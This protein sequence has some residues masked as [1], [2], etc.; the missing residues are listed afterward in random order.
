MIQLR[1]KIQSSN[2]LPREDP[3]CD[4]HRAF[5]H[6]GTLTGMKRLVLIFTKQL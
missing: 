3:K 4:L 5:L 1:L 2:K 6:I